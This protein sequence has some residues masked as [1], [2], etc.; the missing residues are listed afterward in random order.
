M[1]SMAREPRT[2][3]MMAVA[4]TVGDGGAGGVASARV[5]DSDKA[6]TWDG[7]AHASGTTAGATAETELRMLHPVPPA[8]A[9]A[10]PTGTGKVGSSDACPHQ[11]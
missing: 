2:L 4:S 1:V 7:C 11:R 6:G 8:V 5:A 10:V 3:E 9:A